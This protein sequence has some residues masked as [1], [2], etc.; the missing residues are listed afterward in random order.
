M[1]ERVFCDSS[2]LIRYLAD[3]DPPR[4]LAAAA[5]IDSETV[6]V[7]STVVLIEVVHVLRGERA[8]ENPELAQ[9]LVRFLNR[10]NVEL[11]DADRVTAIEGLRGAAAVSA[12]RIPDALIAAAAARAQC[13][14]IAAFDRDF[15]STTVPV[16]L[17]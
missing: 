12:R 5:L 4:A 15:R 1:T 3:D 11:I 2:V 9:G 16:R 10:Q 7:V 14:W 17:I 8:I 13:G 6:V